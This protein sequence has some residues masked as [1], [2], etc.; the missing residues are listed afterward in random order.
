[1][2]L[3]REHLTGTE[4]LLVATADPVPVGDAAPRLRFDPAGSRVSG[5]TGCNHLTGEYRLG[6]DRL[7]FLR[8]A[9][10]R[11][12]CRETAELERAFLQVLAE[13]RR[14]VPGERGLELLDERGGLLARFRAGN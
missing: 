4:W 5:F 3:T 13:T 7:A 6:D 8:V 10:T 9:T 12:F 14:A 1:M 2:P 11:R